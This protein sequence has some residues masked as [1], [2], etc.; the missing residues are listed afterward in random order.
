MSI[1]GDAAV[2]WLTVML[3]NAKG[4]SGGSLAT[5]SNYANLDSMA[6]AF[7]EWTEM[8]EDNEIDLDYALSLLD[9]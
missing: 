9:R 5:L 4:H 7:D 8:A 6:M 3:K 2:L 1:S